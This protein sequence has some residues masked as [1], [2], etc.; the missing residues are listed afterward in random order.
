MNDF[1]EYEKFIRVF[2]D[3]LSFVLCGESMFSTEQLI[4]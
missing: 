2:L 3:R 1:S 4:I